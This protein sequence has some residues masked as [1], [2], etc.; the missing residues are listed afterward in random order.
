M[1][2]IDGSSD[3]MPDVPPLREHYGVPSVC[4]AGLGFPTS[5]LLLL[6]D[7]AS[8]LFI[9]CIDSPLSTSDLSQT[10]KLHAHLGKGDILLGDIAFAGWAHLALI[11]QANLHAVVPPHHRRI[12]DFT[13]DRSH[14]HPRKGKSASRGGKPRSRV[15]KVLGK[16]DQLVECFKPVNQPAW[17]SDAQWEA[18]PQSTPPREIRRTVKR[19]G[20]RPIVVTIVTTLL[21]A[22]TYPADE[23]IELRLSRWLIETNIRHLKITLKMDELKCRTLD[24]VRK[25]RMIFLLVYNLIRLIMLRAA[26]R[27]GV[28]INRL[29]FA[30]T[31]AWLRWGAL[32]AEL[33]E[34]NDQP[35]EARTPG[36][37]RAQTCEE[38]VPA[39]DDHA[40]RAQVTTP[41]QIL[42][43]GLTSWH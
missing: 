29:S 23:L 20:F 18:L 31:L 19:D 4:R 26:K 2:L 27:Q 32:N 13:P 16:D 12:V 39:H 10:Q 15:I 6:M 1:H 38:T 3:S 17:I 7:R 5:H 8:G 9:D 35:I 25:E 40:C 14:A 34:L 33:E 28:N 41:R 30:D 37:T 21:D 24:G 43:Y 11:T 42:G 36:A 22:E